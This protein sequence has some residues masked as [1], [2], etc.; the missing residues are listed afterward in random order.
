MYT[1][2]IVLILQIQYR[3]NFEV[4]NFFDS[5]FLWHQCQALRAV[6][7]INSLT[8]RMPARN[9]NY[10]GG[11]SGG[12][13][14]TMPPLP[15]FCWNKKEN[16]IRK[17]QSI[18]NCLLPYFWTFRHPWI[19]FPCVAKKPLA[20]FISAFW[21]VKTNST[22]PVANF[23]FLCCHEVQVNWKCLL[24]VSYCNG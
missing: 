17:K 10:R 7:Q 9:N 15:I 11:G 14:G 22:F 6:Y 2:Q 23:T 13:K 18:T 21:E 20:F 3:K 4:I 12:A 19:W 1:E 24:Q 16:R 8:D 5:F